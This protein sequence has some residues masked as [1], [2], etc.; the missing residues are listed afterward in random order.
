MFPDAFAVN[1]LKLRKRLVAPGRLDLLDDLTA[2][3][4]LNL[5][6][7]LSLDSS[8]DGCADFF[9]SLELSLN[10]RV[11]DVCTEGPAEFFPNG[12]FWLLWSLPVTP[13]LPALRRHESL[14]QKRDLVFQF[15][16]FAA[17][18]AFPLLYR[19]FRNVAIGQRLNAALVY[20][21]LPQRICQTGFSASTACNRTR[22]ILSAGRAIRDELI[23]NPCKILTRTGEIIP[24]IR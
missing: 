8:R 23:P 5:P 21:K 16:K 13:R 3:H 7:K 10:V 11:V 20:A 19:I 24:A 12:I 9:K 2:P 17:I 22:I 4:F 15:L 6:A 14:R 1:A 18:L